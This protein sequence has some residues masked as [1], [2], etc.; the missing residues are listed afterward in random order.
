MITDDIPLHARKIVRDHG[1]GVG[2]VAEQIPDPASQA[3]RLVIEQTAG[4]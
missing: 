4:L 2:G 1:C 3:R